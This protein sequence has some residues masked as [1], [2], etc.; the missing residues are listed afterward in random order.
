VLVVAPF[1]LL[2]IMAQPFESNI[3]AEFPFTL[4]R[5][6]VLQSYMTYIDTGAPQTDRQEI[7]LFIHGNPVSSYLWR[8]IIPHLSP[9]VRCVA[10]ELI[11][12]GSSGKPSIPYRFTDH[13]AYLS[14]FISAILPDQKLI[15]IVQDWGSALGFNWASQNQNR[16]LGLAFWEF[17]RPFP[18]FDDLVGGPS[19]VLYRKFR[20]PVEG[21]KLT[22][23]DNAMIEKVLPN[24]MLRS[25]TK[26]EHD[27]YRR[28]FLENESREPLFRVPN[29]LPIEGKPF[30]VWVI[31]EK[32]HK[33]LLDSEVPKLL[34][35]ATPGRLVTEEKAAWYL[36]NLKNV[37]GVSVGQGLHFLEEDHPHRLGVEL[38]IWLT[39]VLI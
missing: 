13:A 18:T 26:L 12:F 6:D 35:W 28:P 7:A 1:H 11:G 38:S 39:K 15:L 23:E 14:A 24:A 31:W 29:E 4:K 9:Q 16:V 10:P 25:L 5:V 8:N 33:W 27:E 22:I 21:R 37:K 36:K 3:S 2:N 34:F 32:F 30:D 17:L 19:Q 20:D